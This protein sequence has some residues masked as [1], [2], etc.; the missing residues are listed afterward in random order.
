MGYGQWNGMKEGQ[1]KVHNITYHYYLSR[2]KEME[3]SFDMENHFVMEWLWLWYSAIQKMYDIVGTI[4][5]EDSIK[6]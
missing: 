3:L 4:I 5:V 2:F 1:A 6:C